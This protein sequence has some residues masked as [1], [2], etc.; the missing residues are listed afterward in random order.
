MSILTIHPTSPQQ[1]KVIPSSFNSIREL[2]IDCLCLHVKVYVFVERNLIIFKTH[3]NVMYSR[4]IHSS[5]WLPSLV[6]S[7][8]L[9]MQPFKTILIKRSLNAASFQ[10]YHNKTCKGIHGPYA[11]I[12]I[13][14]MSAIVINTIFTK[15]GYDNKMFSNVDKILTSF[16][17]VASSPCLRIWGGRTS[18][19]IQS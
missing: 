17:F 5:F 12:V 18:L 4:L 2:A 13:W 9:P 16:T 10:M 1:F 6:R 7:R 11:T 15:N 19:C 3:S 14:K 8:K